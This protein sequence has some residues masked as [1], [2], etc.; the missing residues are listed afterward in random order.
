MTIM[1]KKLAKRQGLAVRLFAEREPRII[2]LCKKKNRRRNLENQS[3][4]LLQLAKLVYSRLE[5]KHLL[6]TSTS[7]GSVQ[8]IAHEYDSRKSLDILFSFYFYSI[9]SYQ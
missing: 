6:A 1:F 7:T 4:Y 2:A 9:V 3:T 8:A 5:R